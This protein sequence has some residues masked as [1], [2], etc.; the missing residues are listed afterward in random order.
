MSHELKSL[1]SRLPKPGLRQRR[2][3]AMGTAAAVVLLGSLVSAS[4]Q[5]TAPMPRRAGA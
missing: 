2:L 5:A 3:I 4:G 1:L